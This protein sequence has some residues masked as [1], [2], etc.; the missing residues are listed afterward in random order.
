[1]RK[2]ADFSRVYREGRSKADEMLV[3]YCLKNEAAK[4]RLG[5]SVSK[6]VGN[7][8]IRHRVKRLVKEA[9]RLHEDAIR[10]GYDCVVVA[11]NAAR[12]KTYA[13]IEA[14]L[15]TL[16]ERLQLLNS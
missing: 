2:S 12:G 11:R 13:E 14:A 5:I 4:T 15:L 6:K 9:F 10:Q 7:S 3:L 1:M 16:C 8:V